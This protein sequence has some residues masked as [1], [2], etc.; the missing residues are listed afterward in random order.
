MSV[1]NYKSRRGSGMIM[2]FFVL[3]L[4]FAFGISFLS[5]ASSSLI[6][7]KRDELRA[8]ALNCAEAGVE[9]AISI[10]MN[11]WP[12]GELPGATHPSADPDNHDSD[13]WYTDSTS[14]GTGES[15]KLCARIGSGVTQGKVVVTSVGTYTEAGVSVSRTI[16]VALKAKRENVNVWNNVIFG[17]VGQA[18]RS[19]NGNVAIRGS[20]HLLGDGEDYT[21]LD[22]DGHWDDNETYTDANH[23]GRYDLGETYTDVDHDGHRDAREPYV[24]VNGNGT[25]DPALTVTDMASEISGNANIGNNYS[26]MPSDLRNKIPDPPRDTFGGESIDTLGAKLRVKHGRVNVSGSAT[27]GDPNTTGNSMKETVDGAY[28]SD[29]FGGNAGTHSVF[30]DNGY[31]NGYDLG[32]NL[33]KMPVIDSGSYTKDG[34]TYS[35][36]LQYLQSKATVYIGNL[37]VNS[38]TAL[39][40]SGPKGSLSI[41]GSGNMTI[42]GVVYV[43]GDITFGPKKSRIVYQGSGT[44]VTPNSSYVHC[45]LIPRTNFPLNDVLGLIAGDRIELATGSGDAQLTMAIAMYAQHKVVSSKQSQIAGTIVSSYYEMSNVPSIYQVPELSNYLPPCMPGGDPIWIVSISVDSWQE[46]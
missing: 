10:L 35:N 4:V 39:T 44:L 23:N 9:R 29:G 33:V 5:M 37:S 42:S 41:D 30:S 27:V 14:L 20:V 2:G 17:G 7:S 13:T 18:G 45:D 38:G 22:G 24:D 3:M 40:I 15:F 31:T 28:V 36:Y 46:R 8:H 26:G 1:I 11:Q 25:R 6:T 16:K 34:T 12:N 19:V 43:T 21:D 32:D